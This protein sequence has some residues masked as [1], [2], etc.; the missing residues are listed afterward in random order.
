MSSLVLS[1]IMVFYPPLE[2]Q[3]GPSGN[4]FSYVS[5]HKLTMKKNKKS[6]QTNFGSRD[7]KRIDFCKLGLN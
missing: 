1:K 6:N 3:M 2:I 4:P 7:P 5:T